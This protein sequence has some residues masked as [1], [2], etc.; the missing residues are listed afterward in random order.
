MRPHDPVHQVLKISKMSASATQNG[1]EWQFVSA[2]RNPEDVSAAR[3]KR[4]PG[5][6][7]P[8]AEIRKYTLL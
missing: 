2:S 8:F 5:G 4:N 6:G 7:W 3:S 1:R